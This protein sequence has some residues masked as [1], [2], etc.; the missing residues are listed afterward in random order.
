M[1]ESS[2]FK[3]FQNKFL[4]KKIL[5]EIQNTEWYHY[6]DYRQYSIFNRRKFKYIKSLEWM[7]T[8]K[9]FQLLKC[10]SINKEYITIEE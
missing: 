10:K 3:V 5:E 6:D 7:V 2:F 8:K 9:Q 4:L 1:N